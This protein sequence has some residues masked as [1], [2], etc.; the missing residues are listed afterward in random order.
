MKRLKSDLSLNLKIF[1]KITTPQRRAFEITIHHVK[2]A[3][4]EVNSPPS[5]IKAL[6][7]VL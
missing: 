4:R 3:K 7:G 6:P 2:G 5:E 1:F